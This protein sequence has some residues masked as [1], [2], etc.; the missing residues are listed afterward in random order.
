MCKH[1]RQS[2]THTC[3]GVYGTSTVYCVYCIHLTYS[4]RASIRV[5]MHELPDLHTV[6]WGGELSDANLGPWHRKRIE[7]CDVSYPLF[8]TAPV[9]GYRDIIDGCHRMHRLCE[10]GADCVQAIE[11]TESELDACK[12][13]DD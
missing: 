10:L 5:P 1:F 13:A 9:D 3:F 2:R 4:D 8:V 12:F 6:N 7:E 11:L